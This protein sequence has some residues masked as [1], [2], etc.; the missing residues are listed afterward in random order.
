MR[1]SCGKHSVLGAGGLRPQLF[2]KTLQ[3]PARGGRGTADAPPVRKKKEQEK[4]KPVLE[5]SRRNNFVLD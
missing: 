5:T 2:I 3:S 1:Q 4:S